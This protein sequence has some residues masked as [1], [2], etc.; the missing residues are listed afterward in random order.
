MLH[1]EHNATFARISAVTE[2]MAGPCLGPDSGRLCAPERADLWAEPSNH[3]SALRC[4]IADQAGAGR[5]G[6][7]RLILG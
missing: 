5:S 3:L 1:R 4:L 6:A 7:S 2:L